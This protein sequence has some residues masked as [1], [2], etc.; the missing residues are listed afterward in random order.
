MS[1]SK[2]NIPKASFDILK[3]NLENSRRVLLTDDIASQFGREEFVFSRTPSGYLLKTTMGPFR[4]G[5]M[6]FLM[7]EHK[8]SFEVRPKVNNLLFVLLIVIFLLATGI[9]YILDSNELI[10]D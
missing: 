8:D 9:V 6:L 4:S 5:M 10:P 2:F 3:G 7:N 1:S